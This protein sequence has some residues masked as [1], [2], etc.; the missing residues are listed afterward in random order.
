MSAASERNDG[1]PSLGSVPAVSVVIPLYNK[2]ATIGRALE[3]V[4]RQTVQD[5][6]IIVVNDGSRDRSR[7]IV[8]AF[9]DPR[10][11]LID[12]PNSGAAAARNRGIAEAHSEL[13]AFLDA[14]DEWDQDHL[15][16]LLDLRRRFPE[17]GLIATSYRMADGGSV[18]RPAI[19][20]SLPAGWEGELADYFKVAACSEPPVS[21]SAAA[22]SKSAV[23][24]IGGFPEG[25]I[26]GRTCWHGRGLPCGD[27]WRFRR[28]QLPLSILLL[29]TSL[30]SLRRSAGHWNYQTR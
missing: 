6:E 7:Q 28:V 30:K 12:Q 22:V 14:D 18:C 29:L 19:L 2:E 13:V 11:R 17:S 8:D 15:E 9:Q 1:N 24:A 3:S 5:F 21:T 27:G 4:F 10:L 16:A 20:R 26:S 25:V 23:Q